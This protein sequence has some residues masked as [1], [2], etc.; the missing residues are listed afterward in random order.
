MLSKRLRLLQVSGL[1][2]TAFLSYLPNCSTQIYRAQN[3]DAILVC[4]RGTPIWQPDIKK[5]HLEFTFAMKAITL[6]SWAS[7]LSRKHL[8]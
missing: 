6:R 1:C 5:K 2:G 3:G 4:C 8:T 7:I